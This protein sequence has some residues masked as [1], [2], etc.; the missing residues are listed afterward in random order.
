MLKTYI[1]CNYRYNSLVRISYFSLQKSDKVKNRK[2]SDGRFGKDKTDKVRQNQHMQHSMDWSYF[3]WWWKSKYTHYVFILI[4]L[5]DI[6]NLDIKAPSSF[7]Y[8]NSHI[9]LQWYNN[10]IIKNVVL[11]FLHNDK[12]CFDPR[13]CCL[14]LYLYIYYDC[15]NF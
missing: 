6:F 7:L 8:L 9:V 14:I 10:Y 2:Y 12:K 3:F 4:S 15:I 11:H 5:S 1:L 13:I